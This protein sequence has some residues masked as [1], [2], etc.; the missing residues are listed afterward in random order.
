[1]GH[2]YTPQGMLAFMD[3]ASQLKPSAEVG[4]ALAASAEIF[5][6]AEGEALATHLREKAFPLPSIATMR[7]ARLKLDLVSMRF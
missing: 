4:T 3:L 2:T 5:F 7:A 6:G 1:M